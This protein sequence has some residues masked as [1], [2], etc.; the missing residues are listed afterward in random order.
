MGV[1]KSGKVEDED[2]NEE[3]HARGNEGVKE[4][5]RGEIV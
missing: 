5:E 1:K 2:G 3:K 4:E